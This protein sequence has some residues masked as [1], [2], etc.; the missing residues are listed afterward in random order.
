MGRGEMTVSADG[1]TAIVRRHFRLE[2]VDLTATPPVSSTPLTLTYGGAPLLDTN[3]PV[4]DTRATDLAF[5]DDGREI[6]IIVGGDLYV[7]DTELREPVRITTTAAHERDP[8]SPP[9]TRRSTSAS[10][11]G[12][13]DGHLARDAQGHRQAMVAPD[14]VQGRACDQPTRKSS[15]ICASR[16]TDLD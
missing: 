2:R 1:K 6:A 12:G 16:P 10:G 14:C 13:A 3:S 4:T 11:A 7:M 8:C 15:P 9:I 5:T